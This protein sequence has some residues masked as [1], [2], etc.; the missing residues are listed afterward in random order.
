MNIHLVV[1]RPFAGLARGEIIVDT[2]RISAILASEHAANVVRVI[3]DIR[4]GV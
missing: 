1:V 3:S 2:T 4:K